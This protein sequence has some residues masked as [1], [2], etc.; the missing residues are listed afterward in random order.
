MSNKL[1]SGVKSL[2]NIISISLG[3]TFASHSMQ[4][5][6]QDL[7]TSRAG[8][9]LLKKYAERD[10]AILFGEKAGTTQKWKSI[11]FPAGQYDAS[12]NKNLKNTA[13]RELR[14]ETGGKYSSLQSVTQNDLNASHIE[15]NNVRLYFLDMKSFGEVGKSSLENAVKLAIQDQ[16]LS[17]SCKE[18]SNYWAVRVQDVV[19]AAKRVHGSEN[20]ADKR[21]FQSRGKGGGDGEKLQLES[22]YM[23]V[24]A[25][26]L[27]P[28]YKILQE[29]TGIDYSKS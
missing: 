13:L 7:T 26:N 27:L 9:I 17:H 21:R 19:K 29:I 10:W 24:L 25:K 2:F 20:K 28:L 14:E 8:V 6:E 16:T 22:Y 1:T 11:N 5:S 12:D 3:M 4:T 18:V 23:Q 15:F